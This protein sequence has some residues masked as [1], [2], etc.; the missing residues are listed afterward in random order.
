[1]GDNFVRLPLISRSTQRSCIARSR[2]KPPNGFSW[3]V[4]SS[5][6]ARARLSKDR[7]DQG[8]GRRDPDGQQGTEQQ[9]CLSRGTDAEHEAWV[10]GGFCLLF[11]KHHF[12]LA[13]E[14]SYS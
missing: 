4:I 6:S 7:G 12:P 1:M 10:S 13:L 9:G 5:P 3:S 14:M 2:A 11:A 8:P